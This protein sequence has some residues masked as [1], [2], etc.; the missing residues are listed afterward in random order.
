MSTWIPKKYR[1]EQKLPNGLGIVTLDRRRT[2]NWDPN[3][4]DGR[5]FYVD[6]EDVGSHAEQEGFFPPDRS[7]FFEQPGVFY[8]REKR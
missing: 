4:E 7:G 6:C 1:F 8:S 2:Y 5:T 3:P